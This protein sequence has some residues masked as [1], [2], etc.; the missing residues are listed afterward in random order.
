MSSKM[1]FTNYKILKERMAEINKGFWKVQSIHKLTTKLSNRFSTKDFIIMK[2]IQR[3]K[4]NIPPFISFSNESHKLTIN[5]NKSMKLKT[6]NIMNKNIFI[7]NKIKE[8]IN[9]TKLK[10]K[11]E[12]RKNLYLNLYKNFPYEPYLYNELQFIYLQGSNKLIPRKFNEVIKDCFIMDNYKKLLN[13]KYNLSRL[14][15]NNNSKSLSKFTFPSIQSNNYN[16]ED[17]FLKSISFERSINKRKKRNIY[18]KCKTENYELEFNNNYLNN[19]FSNSK[20]SRKSN[21]LSTINDNK[22]LT[23]GDI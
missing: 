3:P 22:H 14:N 5:N 19:K 4:Q 18:K 15:V 21:Y 20:S 7:T 8:K 17:K 6:N 9:E 1:P 12:I 13:K 10:S 16:I 2:T 23:E 11:K